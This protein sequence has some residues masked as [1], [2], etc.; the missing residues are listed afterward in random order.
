MSRRTAEQQALERAIV[1]SISRRNSVSAKQKPGDKGAEPHRQARR[2]ARHA[3]ADDDQKTSGHE[4]FGGAR[5]RDDGTA[6]TEQQA[7]RTRGRKE[8]RPRSL[9]Q[10]RR[11]PETSRALVR[12]AE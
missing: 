10:N 4:Q 3:R 11:M 12:A 8:L 1:T 9:G 6:G 5:G 7:A 2:R